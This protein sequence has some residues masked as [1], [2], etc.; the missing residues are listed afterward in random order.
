[1]DESLEDLQGDPQQ[2]YTVGALWV[3]QW[4]FWFWDGT[5]S[6]LPQIFGILSWHMQKVRKSQNQ[7]LHANLAW[8]KNSRKIGSR[9]KDFLGFCFHRVYTLLGEAQ[10]VNKLF[11]MS[12]SSSIF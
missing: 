1:M 7:D 9:P 6:A 3:P 10:E 12:L 2:G 4:L 8:S 5:M 11:V